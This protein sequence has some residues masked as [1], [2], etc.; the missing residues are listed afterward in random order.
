M[1]VIES[2]TA[3]TLPD[4]EADAY[5]IARAYEAKGLRWETSVHT[6]TYAGLHRIVLTFT[7]EPQGAPV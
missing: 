7:D 6:R 1:T 2:V 5:R 3:A 4:A